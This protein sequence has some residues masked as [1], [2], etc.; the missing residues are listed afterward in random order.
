[1]SLLT[2]PTCSATPQGSLPPCRKALALPSAHTAEFPGQGEEKEQ[3]ADPAEGP[4]PHL[5]GAAP[6]PA[7][8][9][10]TS[11][12]AAV[13]PQ[14]KGREG[15]DLACT[16]VAGSTPTIPLPRSS[17]PCSSHPPPLRT[18]LTAHQALLSPSSVACSKKGVKSPT[19]CQM[20]PAWMK[21]WSVCSPAGQVCSWWW[22]VGWGDSSCLPGA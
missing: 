3:Q 4:V 20:A 11:S 12:L 18:H 10:W 14:R 22:W 2:G 19:I 1:M 6:P 21:F 9:L 7:V 5:T 13:G 17:P 16:V 15:S 8:G